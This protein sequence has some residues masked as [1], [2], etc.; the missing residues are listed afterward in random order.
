MDGMSETDLEPLPTEVSHEE[1][2][3]H[4]GRLIAGAGL[5]LLSATAGAQVLPFDPTHHR[6]Y[7]TWN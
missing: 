4:C 1:L 5:P 3:R 2:Q 6:T 7:A